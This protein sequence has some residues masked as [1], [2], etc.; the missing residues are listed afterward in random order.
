MSVKYH[1]WASEGLMDLHA[2]RARVWG[3]VTGPSFASLRTVQPSMHRIS[4]P[5]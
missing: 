2:I 1:G 3:R 4:L 5:Y